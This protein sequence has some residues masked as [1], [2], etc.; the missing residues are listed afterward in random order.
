MTH[1]PR[2]SRDGCVAKRPSGD[3]SPEADKAARLHEQI[4]SGQTGDRPACAEA[5]EPRG[6]RTI[7]F[8]PNMVWAPPPAGERGGTPQYG[9]AA[10][11]TCPWLPVL[12]GMAL[13][14]I[15]GLVENV[16]RGRALLIRG[17]LQVCPVES[18]ALG[19]ATGQTAR[20]VEIGRPVVVRR[21]KPH[22]SGRRI[23]KTSATRV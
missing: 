22:S 18:R 16:L 4:P 23:A 15:T 21:A 10:A 17:G 9:D 11:R 7:R 14:L 8:G 3:P 6:S 2:P 13:R 5:R 1:P 20:R 12:F 19:E